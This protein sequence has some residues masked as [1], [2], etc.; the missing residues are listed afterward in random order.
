MPVYR[1]VEE[2]TELWIHPGRRQPVAENLR[3]NELIV[4]DGE[5]RRAALCAS[6]RSR[7]AARAHGSQP[8][9]EP[10]QAY[11]ENLMRPEAA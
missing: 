5:C 8:L 3:V 11:T 7:K 6:I 10:K 2:A 9:R 4:S 1:G